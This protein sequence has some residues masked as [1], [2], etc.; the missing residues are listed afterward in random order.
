MLS[1]LRES[2][3]VLPTFSHVASQVLDVCSVRNVFSGILQRVSHHCPFPY[4]VH[5]K[6]VSFLSFFAH[7]KE[8]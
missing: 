1:V 7:K 5:A 2:L 8:H 3:A 6:A 4:H